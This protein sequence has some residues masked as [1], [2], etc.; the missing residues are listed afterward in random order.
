MN[1][2][3]IGAVFSNKVNRCFDIVAGVERALV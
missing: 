2:F 1:T 3:D